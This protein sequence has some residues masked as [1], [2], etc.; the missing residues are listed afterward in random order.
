MY[1]CLAQ[2]RAEANS[3]GSGCNA[4]I[5]FMI[6]SYGTEP[7]HQL[8]N[9]TLTLIKYAFPLLSYRRSPENPITVKINAF[10]IS[11]AESLLQRTKLRSQIK[12]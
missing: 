8:P 11:N 3:G 2:T 4:C 12:K 9:T 5:F 10:L 6:N 1:M 7:S